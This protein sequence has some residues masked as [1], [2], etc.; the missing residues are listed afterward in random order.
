[1]N[2][3]TW[4]LIADSSRG[5]LYEQP[6]KGKPWSLLEQYQH[7]ASRVSE[8][9]LTTDQPGRMHGSATG[10][11]RSAMESKTSPKEV[12]FERF[13]HQL[14]KVLQDGHGQQSY[15][16][17][18]LVAPPHFLGLLRKGLSAAV[19]KMIVATLDR[20]YQHLSELEVR[21]QLVPL[22]P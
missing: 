8:G 4:I 6:A 9:G 1:M 2:L 12:E 19:S 18:V 15:A 10:G 17:L 3:A 20:D 21:K 14:T 22:I 16:Q 7:P 13:A 5:R 11:A